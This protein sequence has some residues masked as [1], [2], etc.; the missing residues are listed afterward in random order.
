MLQEGARPLHQPR[1]ILDPQA[2]GR[3]ELGDEMDAI[4]R[5]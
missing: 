4:A 1:G 3:G 5:G 2:G